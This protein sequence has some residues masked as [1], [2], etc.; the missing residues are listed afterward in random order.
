MLKV[1]SISLPPRETFGDF[2]F[3]SSWPLS[4]SHRETSLPLFNLQL[5]KSESFPPY[6]K[7]SI[8]L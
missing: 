1:F 4:L 6:L 3:S 8:L 7:F 2:L 5:A